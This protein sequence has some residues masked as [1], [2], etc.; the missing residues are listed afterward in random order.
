V[1][2]QVTAPGED[3]VSVTVPE[4]PF[5]LVTVSVVCCSDPGVSV[6]DDG[7][8]VMLKLDTCTVVVIVWLIGAL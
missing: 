3:H 1:N 4:N 5:T 7:F 2:Q 8:E 6:M